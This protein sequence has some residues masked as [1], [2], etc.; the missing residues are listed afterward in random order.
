MAIRKRWQRRLIERVATS[1]TPLAATLERIAERYVAA[2]RGNDLDPETNGEYWMLR[3]L[4]PLRPRVVFDVGANH[5]EWSAAAAASLPEAQIHAFEVV[6]ATARHLIEVA[7]R[8]PAV[9][10]NTVGLAETDAV[11]RVNTSTASDKVSSLLP[12]HHM[13]LPF[14]GAAVW[15][16]IEV[17]VIRGDRYCLEQ[18]INSIDILKID[19]EGAEN[20]VIAGFG[21]LVEEG[22]VGLIQFEYGLANIHSHYLL[23]DYYAHLGRCGYRIGKL[24]ASHVAF[25]DYAMT[26]EDF[27]GPNYVAVHASRS[28]MIAVLSA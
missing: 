22:R 21:A 3:R 13:P 23:I 1:R 20:R 19:V 11:L 25:K 16:E 17:D 9:R 4:A 10:A 28:D 6:P 2:A 7:A 12:V 5:G 14:L 18:G 24:M 15:D 27:L 26:D 8:L